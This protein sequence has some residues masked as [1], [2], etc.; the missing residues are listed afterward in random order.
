M[1][2]KIG[3]HALDINPYLHEFFLSRFQ[4]IKFLHDHGQKGKF[5]RGPWSERKIWPFLKVAIS[6]KSE[7]P[8]PPKSVHMHSISTLTCMNF[9]G[10]FRLIK[11]LHDHGL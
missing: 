3:A 9:L 11:F 6:P 8:H 4:S 5:G 7:R 10:R 2:T 1:P